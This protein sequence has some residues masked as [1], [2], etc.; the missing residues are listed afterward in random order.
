MR[1]VVIANSTI[2]ASV[3]PFQK[4]ELADPGLI[5]GGV[6]SVLKQ[7]QEAAVRVTVGKKNYELKVGKPSS[8]PS[9]LIKT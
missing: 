2:V 8:V 9:S 6:N 3:S 5:E 7:G 4:F 1:F